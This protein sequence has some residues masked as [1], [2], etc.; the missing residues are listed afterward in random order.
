MLTRLETIR[1]LVVA[2][3]C[4]STC[5]GV[6]VSLPVHLVAADR[7][8]QPRQLWSPLKGKTA[9]GESARA[10]VPAGRPMTI[11]PVSEKGIS[12][13]DGEGK[14]GHE[15]SVKL[16][17]LS[18]DWKKVLEDVA[19]SSNSQLV[20]MDEPPGRFSRQ[21]WRGLYT[22]TEAIQILNRD[23]EPLGY[24]ILEKNEFLTVIHVQRQR[25]EYQ[26]PLQAAADPA[27]RPLQAG[28]DSGVARAS[29]QGMASRGGIQR[30]SFEQEGDAAA[31]PAIDQQ[32]QAAP[33]AAEPV[34]AVPTSQSFE[35]MN[36]SALDLSK[37][38]LKAFDSRKEMMDVGPT[39]LPGFAVF[40]PTDEETGERG[41]QLFA[42]ELDVDND[43]I[44]IHGGS[45]ITGRMVKLLTRLD[46]LAA[47]NASQAVRLIPGDEP[48]AE[49]A[50]RIR[51]VVK[52]LAQFQQ[53]AVGAGNATRGDAPSAPPVV[54]PNDPVDPDV[55]DAVQSN[56]II[57]VY[58]G[59]IILRGAKKDVDAVTRMI[60]AIE[61][62]AAGSLPEVNLVLLDHADAR[63]LA[64]IVNQIYTDLA[65]LR[66]RNGSTNNQKQVTAIAVNTPNAVLLLSPQ[67]QF[68]AALDVVKKLDV[69]VSPE[70]QMQV[71][72]LKS[73]VASQVVE[74]IETL[75]PSGAEN[76]SPSALVVADIRTNSVVVMARPRDMRTI[77]DLV[78]KLDRDQA[79]SVV[80]QQRFQL[81]FAVAQELAT[82]LSTAIQTVLNPPIQQTTQG[83]GQ[84]GQQAAGGTTQ[85]PQQLRDSKAIVL[86]FLSSDGND[87]RLIKSGLLSDVRVIA[88]PRTNS[89]LVSAPENS[90]PLL[91]ELI[92]VLDV[93]SPSISEFKVFKLYNADAL[94]AVDLLTQLFSSTNQAAGQQGGVQQGINL[95]GA[96]DVSSSL[97]PVQFAG[98][99]R[100]NS[101]I[102]SGGTDAMILVEAILAKL[103]SE[104]A[105]SR[106]TKVIR[107][108]NTS[109]ADVE[110]ALTNFLA[111]IRELAQLDPERTTTNQLLQQEILVASD[112]ATNNLL[113]S[114]TPRYMDDVE[115]I[116]AQLDREPDQVMI[117]A[118]LVEV[119]LTG[120]C[121][122]GVEL[123]FQ[124]DILFNRSNPTTGLP[125][126]L[127][128]NNALGN[129]IAAANPSKVGGQGL[130]NFNLGR[131][132][133]EA[134]FGGLVLA[135]SSNAVSVLIRAL[136]ANSNAQVLSRPSILAVDNQIAEITVGQLVPR[137]QGVTFTQLGQ[138]YPQIGDT[139]VGI[140]LSVIPR[141]TP[142]GKIIMELIANNSALSDQ[143]VPVFVNADGSTIDSP[144]INQSRAQTTVKVPDGQTIVVGG[145]ITS[146]DRHLTRKV[147]WLGDLPVIGHAFRFD[148]NVNNRTE[149]IIFL[150][151]RIVRRDLDS[152]IIKQV[153]AERLNF[154]ETD[155]ETM[156]GPLF[157]VPRPDWTPDCPPEGVPVIP[158]T[159]MPTHLPPG[160]ITPDGQVPAGAGTPSMQLDYVPQPPVPMVEPG[161]NSRRVRGEYGES[162]GRRPL[163][164]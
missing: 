142:E 13:D 43:R 114:A 16:N 31:Q 23:L 159:N 34:A 27:P 95:Q 11:Q 91:A 44:T 130:S 1:R 12:T 103:D 5:A 152:E 99:A 29:A 47:S 20:M 9:S 101:V 80:R 108:R 63:Q 94:A 21:D 143:S 40:A 69:P 129:N 83:Q 135:A 123:G 104:N 156:H 41:E 121:E 131:T 98:D 49:I 15:T 122:F 153:E 67:T 134:G 50:T 51:P 126:F 48:A 73:A 148:Q 42:L 100:T 4:V 107:L 75:F 54:D 84:V 45:E 140:I 25:M 70:M 87:E 163:P 33:V 17:Y 89:L 106:A 7:S 35:P 22:R 154:F 56:V 59:S 151:P 37:Q 2:S 66:N 36:R 113:V 157:G 88:E 112:P 61:S 46:G 96:Q 52:Q 19:A 57:E 71:F 118:I 111:Q 86:E 8:P 115:R 76:L 28:H 160:S 141:I 93:Q 125:G 82:F 147:P 139:P 124:D 55:I 133:S 90:M 6:A 109:A 26:R 136:E 144:I 137:S 85:G 132:S 150:T 145:M 68:D 102:A 30:A 97:V 164:H 53:G 110:L 146:T 74:H 155:V 60:R 64:V 119:T 14:G 62:A 38:L 77:D 116:I 117:Q 65:T 162:F 105:L 120:N 39:G 58:E 10:T 18:A 24:R 32:P 158:G 79:A 3:A 92:R 81:Q 128:N 161:T 149:L 127:F 138:A 72:G 78:K